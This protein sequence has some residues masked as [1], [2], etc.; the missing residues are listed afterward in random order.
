M[1]LE[2]FIFELHGSRKGMNYLSFN[3]GTVILVV[4]DQLCRLLFL[5][6]FLCLIDYY[7]LLFSYIH[8][9]VC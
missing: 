2:L 9:I 6:C 4:I 3:S 8:K 1:G 5:D 7:I